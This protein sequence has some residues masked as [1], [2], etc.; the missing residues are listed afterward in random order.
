LDFSSPGQKKVFFPLVITQVKD[1]EAVPLLQAAK[2]DTK[3]LPFRESLGWAMG[4]E[5]TTT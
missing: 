4:V 1:T 2:P 5:P 3:R